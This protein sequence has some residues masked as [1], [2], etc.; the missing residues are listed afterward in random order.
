MSWVLQAWLQM[1]ASDSIYFLVAQQFH[2]T[3]T[4]KGPPGRG[5]ELHN[6]IEKVKQMRWTIRLAHVAHDVRHACPMSHIMSDMQGLC[7]PCWESCMSHF[8]HDV[9]H[10]CSMWRMGY[11]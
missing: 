6:H 9:V 7:R 5:E 11:K 10:A 3:L 1:P 4:A 8:V 2:A